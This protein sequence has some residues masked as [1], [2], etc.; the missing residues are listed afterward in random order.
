GVGVFD[1]HHPPA[2]PIAAARREAGGLERTHQRLARHRVGL[3]APRGGRGAHRLV[4]LHRRHPIAQPLS[5]L[6]RTR[7]GA[8][9]AIENGSRSSVTTLL[10]PITQRSPTRTPLVTTT[11]APSQ[12][13]SPMRVGPLLS[14]PCQVIGFSGSSKRWLASLTKQPLASMQLSPI[15][16]SCSAATITPRL[17]KLPAPMRTRASPGAVIQTPGSSSTPA[18]TSRR[19]WRS[20]SSTL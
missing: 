17:R 13:L 12:Q 7:A 20:A 16:T 14:N 10:A 15:S 1:D 2:L 19:P 8:P 18:P 4:Q 3:K 5:I 9:A 6:R 11:F